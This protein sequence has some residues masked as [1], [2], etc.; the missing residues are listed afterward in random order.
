MTKLITAAIIAKVP[1]Y[2]PST[3]QEIQAALAQLPDWNIEEG[4]PQKSDHVHTELHRVLKFSS[5]PE[6]MHFM[7]TASRF[8]HVTDHHPRWQ[9]TYSKVE[10]WLTTG[11]LKH[12][13]S[14]K[15]FALAQYLDELF[16]EYSLPKR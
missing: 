9:N 8:V 14:G 7:L 12:Q 5:F 6:A 3:P 15:D 1:R 13:L 10:V 4:T 11:D 2:T 16:K